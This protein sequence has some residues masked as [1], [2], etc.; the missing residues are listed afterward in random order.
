MKPI[1]TAGFQHRA[2]ATLSRTP[3][4]CAAVLPAITAL[5]AIPLEV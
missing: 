5:C 2:D 4:A 3:A 1:G